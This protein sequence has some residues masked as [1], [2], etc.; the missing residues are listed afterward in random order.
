MVAHHFLIYELNPAP[1]MI[2]VSIHHEFSEIF[3]SFPI[4]YKVHPSLAVKMD[5]K[6]QFSKSRKDKQPLK[7][8]SA[9]SIFKNPSTEIAAGYLIDRAGLKGIEKGNAMISKK[10]ANFIINLGGASSEDI[11]Y[12]IKLIKQNFQLRVARVTQ[13]VI[14]MKLQ[15]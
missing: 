2:V 13:I 10:H 12:L 11:I 4:F 3:Q 15:I 7:Y 6:I 1:P 5:K 8:R 14:Q 9:G